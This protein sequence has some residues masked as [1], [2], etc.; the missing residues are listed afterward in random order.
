MNKNNYPGM[1]DYTDPTNKHIVS[2][3]IN[4]G[5]PKTWPGIDVITIYRCGEP[6]RNTY[7]LNERN[8]WR[9]VGMQR[10]IMEMT[11]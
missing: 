6:G 7:P 5:F 10:R 4:S 2:V 8:Y 11:K 3:E 9:A 1:K